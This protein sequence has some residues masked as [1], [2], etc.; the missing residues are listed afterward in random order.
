MTDTP[1]A[2]KRDRIGMKKSRKSDSGGTVSINHEG[3]KERNSRCSTSVG[4]QG[5][6]VLL[7]TPVEASFCW[8]SV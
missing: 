3:F 8:E 7:R 4:T 2:N 1:K 5:A 6:L